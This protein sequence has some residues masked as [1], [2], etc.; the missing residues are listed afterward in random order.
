[1][2]SQATWRPSASAASLFG[3][4]ICP[5]CDHMLVAPDA[6]QH[7]CEQTIRHV[8]SCEA[9]GN[10]FNTVVKFVQTNALASVAAA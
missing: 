1:M 2:S 9:C 7:V 4:Q 6:S 8:W 5:R 3:R 10:E